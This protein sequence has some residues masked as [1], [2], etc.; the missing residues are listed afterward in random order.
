M[1]DQTAL[2]IIKEISGNTERLA[3]LET[4]D[5]QRDNEIKDLKKYIHEKENKTD[6]KKD[7]NKS[8]L[9]TI[10]S[11]SFAAISLVIALLNLLNNLKIKP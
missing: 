3:I 6:S 2:E 10:I 7:K 1:E 4:N 5:K 9:L 11:L 8:I